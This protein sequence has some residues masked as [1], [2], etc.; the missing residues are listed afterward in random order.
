MDDQKQLQPRPPEEPSGSWQPP[1]P[2][3]SSPAALAAHAISIGASICVA[4]TILRDKEIPVSWRAGTGALIL[5][6][7]LFRNSLQDKI[8]T[9][10]L[11]RLPF[12]GRG[13]NS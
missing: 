9:A 2:R 1:L 11:D 5:V 8:V 7:L 12:G 3:S 10:L 4:Q 13:R 6:A